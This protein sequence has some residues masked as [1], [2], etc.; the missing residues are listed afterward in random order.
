[1]FK[2]DKSKIKMALEEEEE[3]VGRYQ[4]HGAN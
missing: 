2:Y 3:E 4:D 1:M